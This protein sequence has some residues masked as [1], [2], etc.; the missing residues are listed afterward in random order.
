MNNYRSGKHAPF[1]ML[2]RRLLKFK[3]DTQ[4]ITDLE[5]VH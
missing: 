3:E 1:K 4:R 2:Y 5:V